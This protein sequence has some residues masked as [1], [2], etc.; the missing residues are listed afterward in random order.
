MNSKD[1]RRNFLDFFESKQHKI[2]PSAPLINKNDPTLMFVNAGMNQFKDYFLGNSK[3]E[4]KR[5]ADTQKCLRVSGKHNDLEDVGLDSYHHTLFEMLGN[6]SFGDYFK[7]EAIQWAWELLTEVYKIDKERIYVTVF[8]GDAKD[9]LSRDDEAA[10]YWSLY[11]EKDRILNFGKKDNFWEMGET[12]P[13][14]PCSEIHVD[15]RDDEERR[16]VSGKDLVNMDNPQVIEIWNNVFIQF[17]RKAGG[18]LETLPDRHVDT[19]MGFER[20]TMVLQNKKSNYETDIFSGLIDFISKETGVKYTNIY[21]IEAK[22]DVAIRVMAD[23]IRAVAFSIADGEMPGNT[24]AGYVIR[25]ILRRAVRYYYSFLNR[26]EPILYLLIDILADY[27]DDIFPELKMQRDFIK[28][29]VKEEEKSFLLTLEHGLRRMDTI[30]AVDGVIT[31]SDAFELYDTYG[32]PIDLIR[33]IAREKQLEVDDKGFDLALQ[34]QKMRSKLDAK[35]ERG[36]WVQVRE[37]KEIAFVGYDN[38][39]V[40]DT[41]VV[42][43]RSIVVKDRKLYQLVLQ[44]TPFYAEGGGQVGDSGYIISGNEKLEVINTER[45]NELIVHILEKLPDNISGTMEAIV[46]IERRKLIENNHSATHLLQAALRKVLGN[47]IQQRGSLVNEKYLRFDFSHFKRMSDDEIRQVENIVNSKIRQN[48]GRI[49]NRELE[50]EEAKKAGAMMIFGEKYGKTV[51]MISFGEDYSIEL[52]GGCHVRNTG[53]IGLFKIVS[54]SAIAAGV[55]RIEAFTAFEAEKYINSELDELKEVKS[56]Y[57]NPQN[58]KKSIEETLNEIKI[59]RK[60]LEVLKTGKASS[61]KE[62]LKNSIELINGIRVIRKQLELDDSKTIKTLSYNLEEEI[63]DVMIL[64]GFIANEKPQLMLTVSNSLTEKGVNAGTLIRE[65]AKEIKGGGGGQAFFAT[66]GGTDIKG[67]HV[68]LEKIE[69]L[70]K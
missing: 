8:G 23:H 58:L 33:L 52:C 62:E 15:L 19:G 46:D 16:S 54:E 9:G 55:R 7:K 69:H 44:K 53:Q 67:I 34:E 10:D 20:L 12:G 49:E 45:E 68:A 1:I 26:S 18:E 66:A 41:S 22:S 56:L 63:R 2:V 17:N 13:C 36:D 51:R 38:Q 43:Y 21:N 5:I 50:I 47:H 40:K 60:E 57:K 11:V 25:R 70:I 4:Y 31:G 39:V 3:P 6:W 42:K 35:V 14:G 27:F 61:L 59:L 24:G 28:N 37:D 64:F 65:I 32:F 30:N 48:I 29:V